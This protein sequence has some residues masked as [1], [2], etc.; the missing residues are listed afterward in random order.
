[1]TSVRARRPLARHWNWSVNPCPTR[2]CSTST[3]GP[4]LDIEFAQ[5]AGE[6]GIECHGDGDI[7]E[8]AE[9]EQ[10]KLSGTASRALDEKVDRGGVAFEVSAACGT[11]HDSLV[12][13]AQGEVEQDREYWHGKPVE[14][15]SGRGAHRLNRLEMA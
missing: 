8:G 12:R 13:R 4:T 1:M 3:S 14:G 2:H 15:C 9:R 5:G 11:R 10:G 6:R 7:R